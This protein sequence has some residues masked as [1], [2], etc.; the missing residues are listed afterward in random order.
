[1]AAV[2]ALAGCGSSSSSTSSTQSAPATPSSTSATN[3]ASSPGPPPAV[4]QLGPAQHPRASQFPSAAGK[5]LKEL[6]TLARSSVDLGAATGTFT[7]GIQRFAF[8]LTTNAG[9]FVSAPPTAL[10]IA[11]EPR[12]PGQGPVPGP[13]RP[14]ERPA[15]VP[16]ASRT[17]GLAGSRRSTAPTCPSPRPAPTSCSLSRGGPRASSAPPARNSR[18]APSSSSIPAVGQHPP[19]IATDTLSSVHG[20]ESLLTTRLPPESMAAASAL[21]RYWARSRL[22]CCSPRRSCASRAC[23]SR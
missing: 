7:P 21:T 8:A 22:R 12:L 11:T 13:R 15:P 3:P 5:S 17:P 2:V 16:G 18:P 9:A 1:M 10:Y 6:G 23:A 4:A 20:N 19:N 14:D